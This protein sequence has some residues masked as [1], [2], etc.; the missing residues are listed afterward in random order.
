MLPRPS[1]S[2]AS[3][4]NNWCVLC[5]CSACACACMCVCNSKILNEKRSSL[6]CFWIFW[7]YLQL[8]LLC[9]D[10]LYTIHCPPV[11]CPVLIFQSVSHS[12]LCLQ[13]CTQG[14]ASQ[15]IGPLT[16]GQRRNVAVVNS[17]YRLQQA[18]TK[19]GGS[20]CST[21]PP[22]HLEFKSQIQ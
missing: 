3:S 10:R 17:L 18:V 16:E 19:V 6:F 4:L 14:D 9:G 7:M 11:A 13:L 21:N 15:V 22:A 2:S 12:S 20:F 8:A 1:S 5:V